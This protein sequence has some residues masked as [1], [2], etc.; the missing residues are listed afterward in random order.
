MTYQ[1]EN[2]LNIIKYAIHKTSLAELPELQKPIDWV[3][4][5][6]MA[7]AHN[8]F[9]LFHEVAY[10]FPEYRESAEY[11]TNNQV[12]IA[13][14]AQQIRKKEIFLELYRAFLK[15]DLHPI[16]MKGIICRKLYGEY[17]E[18]RPS[19]DE[20]ILVKKQDFYKVKAVM[21]EQGFVCSKSDVTETQ[22]EILQEIDFQET[23]SRL[24]IEVHTNAMGHENEMRTQMGEC[25]Q[26]VFKSAQTQEID[27][28]PITMMSHTEHYLFLVLHAFKHF[29]LSG[30][31]VRQVLDIL[32]YQKEF[33]SQI[34]W[35]WV[36][37]QLKANHVEGYWGDLQFIGMQYLGFDLQIQYETCSPMNLLEDIMEVGVFGKREEADV[38]AAHIN[39]ST[40]D[41]TTSKLFT[42]LVAVFPKK[43]YMLTVAPYLE[44]K[45]WL[46][47]VEWI[48]RWGRF[49]KRAKKYDGNLIRESVEKSKKR[50][51]MLEQYVLYKK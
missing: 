44:Q 37:Q 23:R 31:G 19:G 13:I 16:V 47:P 20:D 43:K 17:A 36:K 45:P 22:L 48:K 8:L 27:G 39:L 11:E 3:A 42:W 26:E 2:F 32:L 25:F 9:A 41:K 28:V 34:D 46:L 6:E 21:E 40:I 29:T 14:V 12:A 15:E 10:Q 7:K 4:L 30:V 38:L 49:V 24:M 5:T 1:V 50:K 33:G 51:K 18:H 35:R